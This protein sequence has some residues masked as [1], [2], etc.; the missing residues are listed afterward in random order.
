MIGLSDKL[1]SIFS[2]DIHLEFVLVRVLHQ[3]R[4]IGLVLLR[5]HANVELHVKDSALRVVLDGLEV[6]KQILLDGTGSVGRQVRIVPGVELGSHADEVGMRDHHVYVGGTVGVATHDPEE[7]G[8]GA[9]GVDGVLGRLE[10]VEPELAV[11]VGAELASEI[12][13]GLV[14]GIMRIVLAVGASLPHV[15]DRAGNALAGID[16]DNDAVEEGELAVSGHV[17]YYT[18]AEIAEGGV[19]GPEGSENGG[20][21][22]AAAILE[23]NLVV[24]F[25]DET[26]TR[27]VVSERI[28]SINGGNA[29]R[30]RDKNINVSGL[31]TKCKKK[32]KKIE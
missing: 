17:L 30:T 13:A 16:V 12:V 10:A 1:A 26:A 6:Q 21:G 15:E 24:D 9:G 22:G 29:R 4:S 7:L 32:Q 27:G 5:G 31:K 2:V 8:G 25:V 20:R 28:F 11:L 18:G 19:G 23:D 3:H 14:L